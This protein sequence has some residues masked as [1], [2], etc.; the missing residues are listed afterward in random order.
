V[1]RGRRETGSCSGDDVAM[2]VD[3]GREPYPLGWREV[4]GMIEEE[5]VDS[6]EQTPEAE[7]AQLCSTFPLVVG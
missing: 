1:G 7:C 3:R 6:E 4:E 2:G 5:V